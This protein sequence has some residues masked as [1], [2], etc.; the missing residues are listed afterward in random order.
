VAWSAAQNGPTRST[1]SSVSIPSTLIVKSS[2]LLLAE[3]S[4][5]Y[6]PIVAYTITGTIKLSDY[7]YM[8]PRISSPTYNTTACT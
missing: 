6:T 7:M 3:A 4:Y 8:R 1:G 5:A 2:Q